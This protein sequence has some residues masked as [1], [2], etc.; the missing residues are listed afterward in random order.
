MLKRGIRRI[1]ERQLTDS[2][3]AQ[4]FRLTGQRIDLGGDFFFF[5]RCHAQLT[6][7]VLSGGGLPAT[8]AGGGVGYA[9]S[10]CWRLF[11]YMSRFRRG[12]GWESG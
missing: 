10:R 7:T 3:I 11:S 9:C 5:K 6:W 12:A 1:G 4:E 8:C 2:G